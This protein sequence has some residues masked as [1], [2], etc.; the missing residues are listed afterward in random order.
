MMNDVL[1]FNPKSETYQ[2]F[3][4]EI[5][6]QKAK[7]ILDNHNYDNRKMKMGQVNNIVSSILN[8]GWLNDGGALTFNVEGNITEFQ[9]RLKAIVIS[10]KTV[11]A[12]VVTGVSTDCFT[13]TAAPKP[14]RPVDEIQRKDPDALDSEVTTLREFLQRR[15]GVKL[16][17][18]NA[19]EQW[20]EWKDVIRAGQ[21]IIDG[22]FD[23]VTEY[24]AYRRNFAA[25]AAHLYNVNRKDVAE[26]F[27]GLLQ[28]EVLDEGESY[29]LTKDFMK[30]FADNSW[31]FGN[32]ARATF[33]Y[34]L[35]CVCADRIKKTP[36]GA[37]QLAVSLDKLNHDTLRRKGF[38]RE[39]LYDPDGLLG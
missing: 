15:G 5:T 19:V 23:E 10:Q 30:F 31:T 37:I 34:Q 33:M 25:W 27:L 24:S 39:F 38:Y 13:K 1:G 21:K 16:N 22:F 7:Y 18:Q 4:T 17:M 3:M 14:R 26:T 6:P 9:H 32:A 11:T 8:D 36:T 2:T 35:L 29:K 28:S 12:P 20:D